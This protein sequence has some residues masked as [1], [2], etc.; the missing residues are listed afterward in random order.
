MITMSMGSSAWTSSL[1]VMF[2]KQ[3][4]TYL[5]RISPKTKTLVTAPVETDLG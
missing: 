1:S 2:K 4:Y 3:N 5:Y